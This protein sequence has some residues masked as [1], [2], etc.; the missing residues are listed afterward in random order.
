MHPNRPRG[1]RGDWPLPDRSGAARA[2][3]TV[4]GRRVKD[5]DVG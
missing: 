2:M 1:S 4:V 5:V 3:R